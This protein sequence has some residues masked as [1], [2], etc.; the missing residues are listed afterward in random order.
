M[1]MRPNRKAGQIARLIL[2]YVR[3]TAVVVKVSDEAPAGVV[4]VVVVAAGVAG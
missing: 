2:Y 3:F 1:V 4:V